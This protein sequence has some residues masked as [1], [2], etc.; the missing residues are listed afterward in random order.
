MFGIIQE[1]IVGALKGNQIILNPNYK[2]ECA[3]KIDDPKVSFRSRKE[4]EEEVRIYS[5]L[6]YAKKNAEDKKKTKADK[7]Y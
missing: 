1:Y 6:F 2:N 7:T 4:K 5:A 3:L